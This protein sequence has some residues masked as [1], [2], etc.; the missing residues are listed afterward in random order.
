MNVGLAR[1]Q[2]GFTVIELLVVIAVIG[3]LASIVLVSLKGAMERARMGKAQ[4]EMDQI[5]KAMLVYKSQFGELPPPGDNCSACSNPPN[6]SWTT[7][8]DAMAN[9]NI[10][11]PNHAQALYRDPWGNYYGY[12]NND[13]NSNPGQSY[14]RTA[15]A[16]K[17]LWTA[18]DY[19][20]TVTKSCSDFLF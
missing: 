15:G 9:A 3:L 12:D 16:D 6:S 2:K 8:M 13:C 7:V 14:L 5:K 1:N 10:I 4:T 17:V 11:L 20:I 19:G 18:D